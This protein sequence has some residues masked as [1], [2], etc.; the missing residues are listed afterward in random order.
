MTQNPGFLLGLVAPTT[1]KYR[2]ISRSVM[3]TS[4]IRR[5]RLTHVN[6][7]WCHPWLHAGKHVPVIS[8]MCTGQEGKNSKNKLKVGGLVNL[9][10][11][12][13]RAQC[14]SQGA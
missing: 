6:D 10:L 3:W 9:F 4:V 5:L 12:I 11:E 1:D 14:M 7:L 8:G 2:T 13:W